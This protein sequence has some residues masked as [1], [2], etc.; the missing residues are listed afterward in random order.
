MS[1]RRTNYIL[2]QLLYS[3]CL[4][5]AYKQEWSKATW[6]SSKFV[7]RE[8][9]YY[10]V[11]KQGDK[12]HSPRKKTIQRISAWRIVAVGRNC[13]SS[14]SWTDWWRTSW[15]WSFGVVRVTSLGH[16]GIV[17]K[18]ACLEVAWARWES[19]GIVNR[20]EMMNMLIAIIWCFQ[21]PV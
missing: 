7:D 1:V 8:T 9:C 11:I 3:P 6:D 21:T 12:L 4:A 15:T 10:A 13:S 14:T 17:R 5:N 2:N 19:S 16:Q 18:K 20:K